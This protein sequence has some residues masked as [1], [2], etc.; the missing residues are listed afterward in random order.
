MTH[1]LH[2]SSSDSAGGAARAAYRI[3]CAVRQ[4]GADSK[5]LVDLSSTNDDT[6]STMADPL[7]RVFGRI[8][9]S[10]ARWLRR[11]LKTGNQVI[12]SP[13]LIPSGRAHALNAAAAEILH[14]HWVADEMLSVADIGALRKPVVWTLHDMWAFCGAEHYTEDARWRTGYS[15][16]NRP[17]HERGIDLNRWIWRHKQVSWRTPMHIVTPSHWLADC[18][19]DSALMSDWSVY[20]IANPLD[21]SHWQP[22]EKAIARNLL[23]LPQDVPLIVFGAVGG[24][25]DPRKGFDLL[26]QALRAV[27][28][29]MDTLQLVVFGEPSPRAVPDVQFPLHYTGKLYDD[30]SLRILYSAADAFVLPSRQDNLPNT[31]VESLACATPVIAFNTGGLPDIVQHKV[32]GYLAQPFEPDD[33]ARGIRWVLEDPARNAQ[34]SQRARMYAVQNFSY[35]VV[36]AQYLALYRRILTS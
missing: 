19:R 24:G 1:V 12:H 15:R 8:R 35:P 2:L 23:G 7:H 13:A 33:L 18:V 31:G 9:R 30:L 32:T 3:H 25:K 11:S 29:E 10:G 28:D 6:V 27:R 34:L 36:A 14:L 20:T 5:M 26:M 17:D 16:Y 4:A 22:I 21:V